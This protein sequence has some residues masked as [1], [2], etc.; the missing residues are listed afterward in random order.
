MKW[1]IMR[2]MVWQMGWQ[3]RRLTNKVT[4]DD[5]QKINADLLTA[6]ILL[7]IFVLCCYSSMS[8]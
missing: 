4:C 6:H 2:Q 7:M 8:Y 5:I 1:Q 3:V